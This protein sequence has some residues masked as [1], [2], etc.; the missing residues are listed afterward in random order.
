MAITAEHPV[1]DR[2][3]ACR[4]PRLWWV[5]RMLLSLAAGA[6]VTVAAPPR[7]LWWLAPIGVALLCL[8]LDGRRA[9]SGFGY[10]LLFG[11]GWT[12][13]LLTWLW[14]FLGPG[15]FGPW[16]W[17][18]V[19]LIE[20]V[21]FAAPCAIAALVS[22]LRLAPVWIAASFV[23]GELLRDTLPFGGFPWARLAFTQPSGPLLP[24]ASLAGAP[25]LSFAV[26]L[27]GAS[28]A[29]LAL[30]RRTPPRLAL[31][32]ATFV[33]PL[34][35]GLALWPTIGNPEP[36]GTVR[37]MAIQGSG[38]NIGINLNY[39][40]NVLW[41]RTVEQTERTEQD[42]AKG[43]TRRPDVVV[44]PETVVSL[45]GTSAAD[46]YP[47]ESVAKALGAPTVIGVAMNPEQG[48]PMNSTLGIDPRRGLTGRY[49]KQHL[50]P[51]GEKVPLYWLAKYVTPFLDEMAQLQAGD[52]PGVLPA[53]AARVGI[54]SCYDLGYDD[55]L[56]GAANSGANLLAVPTNNAW[57]G[58]SEMP[59]QQ[60]AMARIRAVEHDRS[61][62]VAATTGTSAIIRPDGG[63]VHQTGLFTPATI[64][65]EVP[66]RTHITL[67]DTLGPWPE[68][69]LAAVGLAGLL[70]GIRSRRTRKGVPAAELT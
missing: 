44:V 33:L 48:K 40:G 15:G 57:Y 42:I 51:F 9:R 21:L 70:P 11:L 67:A 8:V 4:R 7:D 50:V 37:A 46:L 56:R 41:R 35:L 62:V 47:V 53:G 52:K 28:L 23:L 66:L 2:S 19:A 3:P 64:A 65:A 30:L 26:A 59:Y 25:L 49:V 17:L 13:P 16:P 61:V 68:W 54:A 55:V 36:G 18:G 6:L 1:E 24:L 58:F 39:A 43:K 60:Q 14:D 10:G 34:V 29:R 5:L 69:V 27:L 63:V 20:S 38:P 45:T 31:P 12:L 32:T 22:R